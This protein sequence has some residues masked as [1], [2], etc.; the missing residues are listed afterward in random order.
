M[1]YPEP[2]IDFLVYFHGQRDY[3]ECHEVL[4]EYWKDIGETR[5][6][7]LVGLIQIAVSLYHH[8]RGNFVGAERQMHSAIKNLRRHQVILGTLGLDAIKLVELLETRLLEMKKRMPY[9]SIN[10]PILDPK[11]LTLCDK[12][13]TEIGCIYGG[14]SNL[15]DLSLINKHKIRDR[16]SVIQERE[17]QMLLRKKNKNRER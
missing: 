14:P 5:S 17:R 11:L 10:L 13:C 9:T 8:R 1:N 6:S 16:S 3:F 12:R 15:S 7:Y 4:E 2:Y